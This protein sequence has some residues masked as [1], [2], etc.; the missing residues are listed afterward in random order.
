RRCKL[1]EV[2]SRETTPSART[3]DASRYLLSAQPPFLTQ[4]G[5][6]PAQS[7]PIPRTCSTLFA[8]SA[9]FVV[10]CLPISVQALRVGK[11]LEGVN[12][13]DGLNTCFTAVITDKSSSLKTRSM[14]SFFSKPIPCSPLSDPPAA[15]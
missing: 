3:M 4:E 6:L 1:D 8:I 2:G 12:R 15:T 7:F 9:V 13:P 14:N 10:V 5:W 11:I